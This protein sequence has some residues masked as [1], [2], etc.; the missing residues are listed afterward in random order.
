MAQTRSISPEALTEALR[1]NGVLRETRVVD[2]DMEQIGRD[3]GF[4]GILWR[5]RPAYHHPEPEAPASLVAK[6]PQDSSDAEMLAREARFYREFQG[7]IGIRI[8][9]AFVASADDEIPAQPLHDLAGTGLE[10]SL[11]PQAADRAD[12]H[13]HRGVRCVNAT[14]VVDASFLLA[15]DVERDIQRTVAAD[16]VPEALQ[17]VAADAEFQLRLVDVDD[18]RV[19]VFDEAAQFEDQRVAEIAGGERLGDDGVPARAVR[20]GPRVWEFVEHLWDLVAHG[21]LPLK[22][23]RGTHRPPE[24]IAVPVAVGETDP[25][26]YHCVMEGVAAFDALR[27]MA[28]LSDDSC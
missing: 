18:L 10:G 16:A 13:P 6:F 19:L 24:A 27:P 4:N 20:F 22:G 9:R 11:L 7:R 8:P 28:R 21:T 15:V 2:V 23:V 1:R 17:P 3:L 26:A 14:P 25:R 5:V 12:V